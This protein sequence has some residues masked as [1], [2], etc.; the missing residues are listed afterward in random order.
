MNAGKANF[1]FGRAWGWL[2]K[3]ISL[4]SFTMLLFLTIK[5]NTLM[6]LAIPVALVILTLITIYDLKTIVP[7]ENE[8][9]SEKNSY[10]IEQRR[11]LNEIK[12]SIEQLKVKK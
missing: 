7:Q 5:E 10:F 3:F 4:A 12:K 1:I 6:L 11:I 8:Y 9:W 2:S